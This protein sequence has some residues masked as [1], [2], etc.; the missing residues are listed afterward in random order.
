MD[1]APF[2]RKLAECLNIDLTV[3][4]GWNTGVDKPVWE[5]Q[6]GAAI[7]W[8]IPLLEGYNYKF[9]KNL[10]FKPSDSFWG[11]INLEIIYELFRNRYDALIV[12]GWNSCTYWFAF[13]SSFIF[14]TPVL[15]RG[16]NPLNQELLKSKWKILIKKV[17]LGKFL[18]PMTSAF[19]YIG[20]ENR[21]FY[22]Y[23]GVPDD[24]LFFTPYAVDNSRFIT[25]AANL[26]SQKSNLKK[27]IGINSE[28]VVILFVGKLIDK[29]RPL[30][31]LKAFSILRTSDAQKVHL[32]F[33]GDGKLRPELEK[34]VKEHN[35]EN[36]HFVGF[37]NQTELPE[38]YTMADVFVLP[39]QAGETWGLVANEAMCFGL[40]IIVSDVVGC[41]PDLVRDG[42]N[43]YIF[44]V[45]NVKALVE[46]L[47]VLMK[48]KEIREKFGKK[49][50]EI[51]QNYS[52]EEDIRGILSK[53][54]RRIK[55]I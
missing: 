44:P 52:Y 17:L 49:S 37:K 11:Q 47:G 24:K 28:E 31:L 4:F 19:L 53:L 48:N 16:E 45:G 38:Y 32:L 39:S 7:Q 23:Y 18:F 10:S 36:V 3:Y 5:K 41:G 1:Q 12:H 30:D 15:L 29:K 51:I 50:F 20:E 2:F 9:L 33:V 27:K 6:F 21:K 22:K 42:E 35:L 46:R 43:G 34:Y 55:K 13:L 40:S 26:K 14:R 54:E 8:D 25:E